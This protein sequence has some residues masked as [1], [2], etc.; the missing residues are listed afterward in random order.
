MCLVL[1]VLLKEINKRKNKSLRKFNAKISDQKNSS[2][3]KIL[4]AT[5]NTYISIYLFFVTK[6][7]KWT[8]AD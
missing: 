3:N 1:P 8:S 7:G 6:G 4:T 2:F 5:K